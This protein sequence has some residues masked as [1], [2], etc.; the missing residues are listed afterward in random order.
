MRQAAILLPVL[1]VGC[2]SHSAVSPPV[3]VE[4]PPVIAS[5]RLQGRWMITAVNEHRTNGRLWLELGG[6]GPVLITRRPDGGMNIGGPPKAP[7]GGAQPLGPQP[8]VRRGGW[9]VH[10]NN[11][12]M[13]AI[14]QRESMRMGRSPDGGRAPANRG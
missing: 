14:H 5:D 6:E 8:A 1:V 11:A 13:A 7:M 9:M 12:E 2:S 10:N 4:A 3:L